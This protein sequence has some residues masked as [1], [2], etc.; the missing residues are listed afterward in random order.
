MESIES[1]KFSKNLHKVLLRILSE[2]LEDPIFKR[3]TINFVK[4]SK[5]KTF[6]TVYLDLVNNTKPKLVLEKLNKLNG[7]FK[8]LLTEA[9][10]KYRVPFLKFVSDEEFNR[11]RK[12]ES[13][14]NEATKN[15]EDA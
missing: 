6:A 14:I 8:A 10:G 3:V 11:A 12:V 9:L 13:L 4:V 7:F 15:L 2:K 1:K 5:D